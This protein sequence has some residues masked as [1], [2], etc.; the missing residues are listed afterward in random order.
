MTEERMRSLEQ[1][2]KANG[3]VELNPEEIFYLTAEVRH[4]KKAVEHFSN[5]DAQTMIL[6]V[7][8][9][10][11]QEAAS[12]IG[13]DSAFLLPDLIDYALSFLRLLDGWQEE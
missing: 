13:T 9:A 7:V 12:V 3:T 8:R 11:L 5:R 10:D 6:K 4:L 1:F 2:V